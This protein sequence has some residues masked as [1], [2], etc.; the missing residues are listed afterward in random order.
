MLLKRDSAVSGVF[1]YLTESG[2]I[3]ANAYGRLGGGFLVIA[4]DGTAV[5]VEGEQE[6]DRIAERFAFAL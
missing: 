3:V 5:R 1:H 2:R 4:M 6:A